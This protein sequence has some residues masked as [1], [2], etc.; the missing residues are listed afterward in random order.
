MQELLKRCHLPSKL[1]KKPDDGIKINSILVNVGICLRYGKNK[2]EKQKEMLDA[3]HFDQEWL[4]N[5]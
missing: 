2:A 3:W 5:A 4:Q 1:Q